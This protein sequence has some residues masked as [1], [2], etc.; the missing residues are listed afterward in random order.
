MRILCCLRI[1]VVLLVGVSV[2]PVAA[3]EA[4]QPTPNCENPASTPEI[5]FCVDLELR[6]ADTELNREFQDAIRKIKGARHLNANQ[7]RDWE[8]ALREAQR[9]WIAFRDKDCGEVTGWEWYQGTGQGAATLGCKVVKTKV[10]I[11]DL[12]ARYADK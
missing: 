7:R 5:A 10:R 2:W 12:K 8:R 9:H 4:R 6:A 3:Q 1:A 11:E